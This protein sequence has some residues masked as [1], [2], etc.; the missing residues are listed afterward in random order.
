MRP[1]TVPRVTDLE[2]RAAVLAFAR[3]PR[4]ARFHRVCRLLEAR[5]DD[6]ERRGFRLP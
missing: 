5:A 1:P 3:D 4:P 2:L 6:Q